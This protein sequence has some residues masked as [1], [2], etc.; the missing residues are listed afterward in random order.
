MEEIQKLHSVTLHWGHRVLSA[1]QDQS[2]AWVEVEEQS[3]KVMK[4]ITGDFVIGCDGGSSLVRK[5]ISGAN[6]PGWTWPK[7]LVAVNVSKELGDFNP[8]RFDD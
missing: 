4:N 2:K 8:P 7:Q 5:S 1:G 6:F 3:S